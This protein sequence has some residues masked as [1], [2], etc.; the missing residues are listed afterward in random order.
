MSTDDPQAR[1][2]ELEI[3]NTFLEERVAALDEVLIAFTRRVERLEA[4]LELL[5]ARVTEMEPDPNTSGITGV[6]TKVDENRHAVEQDD[7]AS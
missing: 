4:E 3:R 2:T 7:D 1:V 5:R 6:S